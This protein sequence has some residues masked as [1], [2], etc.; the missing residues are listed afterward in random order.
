MHQRIVLLTA[1]LASGAAPQTVVNGRPAVV[2][3]GTVAQVA[4][5]LGGG[6]IVSFQ[7]LDQKLNPLVWAPAGDQS[8]NRPLS[9]FLCLDRWGQPSEA[10]LKN[11]MFFHGEATRVEWKVLSASK[12]QAEMSAYLPMAGLEVRRQIKL[13]DREAALTVSETVTNRNKL[14][15][16][17]NMVQHPTIG[18]PF[19]DESTVV[20]SNGR[21]GFMQSSPMPNPEEPAVWW[22]QALK[23]GQSV[24]MRRLIDDPDPNVVSYVVDEPQG[25]A[26]AANAGKG[27]LIGYVW[28][29]DEY[30]WLNM[31]R[32]VENGKPAARGLEFGTTGLHQPFGVLVKKSRIFGRPIFAYLDAGESVTRSYTAFLVKIPKAYTGVNRVTSAEGTLTIH[33][34]GGGKPLS[35]TVG[36]RDRA[37]R[38]DDFINAKL[39]EKG[40]TPAPRADRR[41]LIRRAT[42]DLHGL[43]P[44]PEEVDAF[45][46]DKS[47]DAWPRLIDR[48][49]ASPRYG[50]RWGRHWLDVVR[51][52]DT[53]GYSNDFE[54]PNAWR[55]RDYVIRSFNH[56]KPYDQFIRE[57]VAGDELD[58]KNPEY[59]IA[60][61]FLRAGPWE[62]TAMSVEAVTRQMFLDDVTHSVA[63]TFLGLTLGC[64]RCHDHK[65]DPIPTRDYYRMQAIFSTTEFVRPPVPFL[66]VENTADLDAG[67]ARMQELVRRTQKVMEPL[68][69][70][71]VAGD[72]YEELRLHQKHVQLYRESLDR[73]EPKAFAVSSGPADGYT[74]GGQNLRYPKRADYKAPE[75]HVLKGGNVTSPAE[76]VEP[77]VL[78]MV[79]RIGGTKAASIPDTFAGR[80][81]AL[82]QWIARGD[83]PFTARVMVNRIWQ[84]HFGRGIA[85]DANNFGRMGKRPTHPELLDWLG[86]QFVERG[87]SI[88]S[89]HREIMLSE[90]Y[91]RA[92]THP[93]MDLV[94]AQDPD[95]K[96][97][98]TYSPRRVEAEVLRDSILAV[99]GELSLDAGGPGTFPQ[100]NEDVARQ[101]QHRMGSLAPAYRPSPLKRQRNRRTVYTFQ[102]RSLIDPI[103]E[104]FNGPSLDLSCERREATVVPTQAFSLFNSQ[105]VNDMALAMAVRLAREAPDP[106]TRV[107]R[108]FRLAY[109]R[110]PADDEIKS[111][112]AH[113]DRMTRHHRATSPPP[114]PA[115]IPVVHTITSELTGKNFRF[116]QQ[117]EPGEYEEN[118]HPRDVS[119][120]TRALADLA[121]VLMNS[122]EFIYVY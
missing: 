17:Y 60:T 70:D 93:R 110:I 9:H 16:V 72:E 69:K 18:P 122:N 12:T 80:R 23:D 83:N 26:T 78:S 101:P 109:G 103:V 108:A 43:P 120:E 77:G 6:S 59:L 14:G 85:A 61:G 48:L 46:N 86:T 81:T 114:P 3:E 121:L 89:M 27:L 55:Y 29:T 5:D 25:W 15:R 7:F 73:Y 71:G 33:P 53:N 106:K 44:A 105:F 49:L 113:L 62:H 102:Q 42:I 104:V 35:V 64:A 11:G 95:N 37:Q 21:R 91:R 66:P 99:S 100:I 58:S 50:E 63:A 40:L 45:V 32:H 31:W 90:A 115:R 10:E 118:L 107:V 111:A 41:T 47:A 19:L 39:A 119:P 75:V 65:F 8:S 51:Y 1:L 24:N 117:E 76:R 34:R 13:A 4:I 28:R 68:K 22:P 20:D 30:P 57:Q 88:K 67:R 56:D 52:A 97:L 79:E 96:L 94:K 98:A 84:Y 36:S 74:D 82:A 116:V 92:G 87:W 38:V 112:L 2:L 54:R